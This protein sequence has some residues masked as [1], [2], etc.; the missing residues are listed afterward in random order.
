MSI[1]IC[2]ATPFQALNAINLVCNSLEKTERKVLFYRDFSVESHDILLGIRKYHIFDCIYE[3]DL[4]SKSNILKYMTNDAIQAVSPSIFV[5]WVTKS[6]IDLNQEEFDTITITS[7]TELEVAL[8]RIYPN[9]RTIAYDDGLGSYVGD[10]VHD[11]KL[12]FIWRLLGRR[13]D[14]IWPETLYIN[15]VEF[16]DSRLS[17]NKKKLISLGEADAGFK[18]MI[19]DIFNV[20]D[21]DLY[22][23]RPLIYLSQPLNELGSN[24]DRFE[25][26]IENVLSEFEKY[27]IYRKHPR[28]SRKTELKFKKDDSNCIWELICGD[29]IDED[30]V[31]ISCCSTAQIMPKILYNKEPWI[32]FTY[33]LY[34]IDKSPVYESRFYP[35][36]TRLKSCYK[37]NY[38]IEE[39]ESVEDLA[40][41]IRKI[42][43]KV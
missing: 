26:S 32:I 17:K 5:K 23:L 8:T 24:M 38:K 30:S 20:S 3:Y 37:Q 12:N 19:Y 22:D 11:H 42:L 14:S 43:R 10:I 28:D 41:V 33:K 39:P 1:A 35:V 15:N 9:A 25:D 40:K 4:E 31:L 18:Y 16:C 7:G 2:A 27:G 6:H 36:I 13:T 21:N 29:K 34:G